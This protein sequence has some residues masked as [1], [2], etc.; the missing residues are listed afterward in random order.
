MIIN[1]IHNDSRVA[2]DEDRSEQ[3]RSLK[4][5]QLSLPSDQTPKISVGKMITD[6]PF[7]AMEKIHDKLNNGYQNR[8]FLD[9][10]RSSMKLQ[11]VNNDYNFSNAIQKLDKNKIK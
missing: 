7:F 6:T 9:N 4:E 8:V 1:E 10:K 2:S 5:N 3:K 11:E